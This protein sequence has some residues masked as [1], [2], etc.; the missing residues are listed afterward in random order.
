MSRE[1]IRGWGIKSL[2]LLGCPECQLVLEKIFR[3][4]SREMQA[5][6]LGAVHMHRSSTVGAGRSTWDRA[7][8]TS[9]PQGPGTS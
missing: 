6:A 9:A 7:A 2:A 3:Q 4:R 8:T 5:L 1:F